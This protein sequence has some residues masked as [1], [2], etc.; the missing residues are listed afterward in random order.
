MDRQTTDSGYFS[1]ATPARRAPVV[2]GVGRV[3]PYDRYLVYTGHNRRDGY[4]SNLTCLVGAHIRAST[5]FPTHSI[6][7]EA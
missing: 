2:V 5:R 1:L 6:Q 3:S 4:R 7:K